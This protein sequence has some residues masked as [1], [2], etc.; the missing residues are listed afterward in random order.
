MKKEQKTTFK[1]KAVEQN[2]DKLYRICSI[3]S[4]DD[5]DAKDLFQEVLCK[6]EVDEHI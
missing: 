3:Y 2:Q 1:K 5:E 6:F 4:K